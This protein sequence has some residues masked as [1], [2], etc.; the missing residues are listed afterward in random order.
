MIFSQ[1][2]KKHLPSA[3]KEPYMKH[4]RLLSIVLLFTVIFVSAAHAVPVACHVTKTADTNDGSC[5]A[6][7]CSLREAVA[8]P[9][10]S[11]IDFSLDLSGQTITLTLG[12]ISIN[13]SLHIKGWGAEAIAISGNQASR[14]FY[15]ATG[16]D[17]TISGVTMKDGRGI[18]YGRWRD[19]G[20]RRAYAERGLPDGQ[21]GARARRR[22]RLSQSQCGK[23]FQFD[24]RL[25]RISLQLARRRDRRRR[26]YL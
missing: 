16:T 21:P 22:G 2:F 15:T 7:D 24:R 23:P 14:I 1:V 8:A 25:Q 20:P 4:I 3:P 12:E 18:F 5:T 26:D 6:S 13:R 10:C 17:V 19:I 9:T 11:L